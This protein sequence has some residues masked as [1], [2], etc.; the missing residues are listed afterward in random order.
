MPEGKKEAFPLEG[1]Y[2]AVLCVTFV[3][4]NILSC[5][6]DF[7]KKFSANSRNFFDILIFVDIQVYYL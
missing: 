7:G 1:G 2:S 3:P 4:Q 5:F 6:F